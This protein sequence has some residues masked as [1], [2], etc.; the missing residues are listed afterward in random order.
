MLISPR[1][2]LAYSLDRGR[3]YPSPCM[4]ILLIA[5][6]PYDPPTGIATFGAVEYM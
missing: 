1:K 3:P 4:G 6:P 5:R 2:Y